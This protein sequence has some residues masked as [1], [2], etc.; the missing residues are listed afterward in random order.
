MARLGTQ[1]RTHKQ[2]PHEVTNFHRLPPIELNA[3]CLDA[4]HKFTVGSREV[5]VLRGKA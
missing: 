4:H 1:C 3:K 5:C 2:R